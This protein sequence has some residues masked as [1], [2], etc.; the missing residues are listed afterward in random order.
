MLE[1]QRFFKAVAYKS[2]PEGFTEGERFVRNRVTKSRFLLFYCSALYELSA[3]SKSYRVPKKDLFEK[4]VR[5]GLTFFPEGDGLRVRASLLTHR[6]FVRNE[7]VTNR[8]FVRVVFA[9]PSGKPSTCTT[10]LAPSVL[11]LLRQVRA[12]FR[13]NRRFVSPSGCAYAQHRR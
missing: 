7:G 2:F 10:H 4:L 11:C 5:T 8:R 6:R 13:T 9:S 3:C 12:Q 1:K